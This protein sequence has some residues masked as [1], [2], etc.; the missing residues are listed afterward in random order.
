VGGMDLGGPASY[1][2]LTEGTPVLSSDGTEI[3]RVAHVLADA[4]A[5]VFDGIVIDTSAGPGGHRFADAELVAEMHELGVVLTLDA[6]A[7]QSLPDPSHNPATLEADPADTAP[8]GVQDRL[9]RAWD[10]ISG[11]Y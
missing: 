1:L 2:T 3:G 5:D 11:N 10:W 9:K 4:D 7:A 6:A 8:D